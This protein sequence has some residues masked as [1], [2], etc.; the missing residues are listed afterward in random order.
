MKVAAFVPDLMDRSRFAAHAGDVTFV[1]SAS[2]LASVDGAD[3]YVVDLGR[4]G[5]IDAVQAL[6]RQGRRVV[7]FGSHVD[8]AL[9]ASARAAG[10]TEVLPRSRFF[11]RLGELFG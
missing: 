9:L 3:L 6:A 7:G 5:A 2:A 1:A 8:V 4:P 10:C 11:A